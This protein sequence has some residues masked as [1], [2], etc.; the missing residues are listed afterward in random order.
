MAR[1][2]TKGK[3]NTRNARNGRKGKGTRRQRGGWSLPWTKAAPA[4]NYPKID[5]NDPV[6]IDLVKALYDPARM[7][8]D[9]TYKYYGIE[10]LLFHITESPA[11]YE[12]IGKRSPFLS[13][14]R[15]ICKFL[16]KNPG[17]RETV[18]KVYWDK[19]PEARATL[20][21]P[22]M[23]PNYLF[24][25]LIEDGAYTLEKLNSRKELF[26]KLLDK[27]KGEI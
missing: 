4:V 24:K 11:Y 21:D 26:R 17:S 6:I 2:I 15:V 12:I 19:Y 1:R 5:V 14:I 23:I 25:K 27:K 7:A 16:A 10:D 8:D 13:P 22:S 3:R 18:N 9:S 20:S